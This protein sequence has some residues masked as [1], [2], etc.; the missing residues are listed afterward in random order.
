MVVLVMYDLW[1]VIFLLT[2]PFLPHVMV[3]VFPPLPSP[4]FFLQYCKT[5]EYIH[6]DR[7]DLASA[8]GC[9]T[10]VIESSSQLRV[11][12]GKGLSGTKYWGACHS[13]YKQQ[14]FFA[15]GA[16]SHFHLSTT[17]DSVMSLPSGVFL[18]IHCITTPK[19]S[20]IKS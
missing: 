20:Y 5:V 7:L 19:S 2:L 18:K 3:L 17:Q 9:Q 11:Q 1:C 12:S 8:V 10:L 14:C 4:D 15:I 13:H 16:L 6:P